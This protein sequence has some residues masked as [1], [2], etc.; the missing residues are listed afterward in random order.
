MRG[1]EQVLVF[2]V[3]ED[4]YSIDSSNVDQILRIPEFTNVPMSLD[5]IR[6]IASIK[7]IMVSI[8]DL[9]KLIYNKGFID[10]NSLKARIITINFNGEVLALLVDDIQ[11]N[12]ILNNNNIQH[13]STNDI[14]TEVITIDDN[15]VHFLDVEKL[16]CKLHDFKYKVRDFSLSEKSVKKVD[17]SNKVSKNYFVFT[18]GDEKFAIETDIIREIISNHE[19]STNIPN[20]NDHTLGLIT[21]REEVL[22]AID[23]RKFFNIEGFESKENRLIIINDAN[24]SVALL[25]DSVIDIKDFADTDIQEIPSKFKDRHIVGVIEIDNDELISIVDKK[26]VINLLNNVQEDDVIDED[27]NPN[28]IIEDTIDEDLIELVI[29]NVGNEEYALDIE[30]IEEIMNVVEITP[31]YGTNELLEGVINLRG[32]IIPVISLHQR[33][34]IKKLISEDQKILINRM[35]GFR[36]GFIVDE[37]TEISSIFKRDLKNSDSEDKLFS[38]IVIL[39]NGKRI[40]LKLDSE[41]LFNSLD[42]SSIS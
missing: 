15:L 3:G 34:N 17:L 20:A 27:I 5:L 25:V 36:V 29:F 40:I 12:V 13:S 18:M 6:G 11:S 33:L 14:I 38:D 37:I 41:E 16:F 8:V 32:G 2:Y 23:F 1:I 9:Y 35:N 30:S 10:L 26:E 22:V 42:L 19:I 21:L 7:G 28:N 24:N 31:I 4:L 39:E